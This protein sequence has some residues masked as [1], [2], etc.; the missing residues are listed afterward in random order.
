MEG[1][2]ERNRKNGTD[3]GKE[4]GKKCQMTEGNRNSKRVINCSTD[5]RGIQKE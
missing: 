4:L 1:D 3:E 2:H 5:E